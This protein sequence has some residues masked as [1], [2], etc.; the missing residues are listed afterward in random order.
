MDC[1]SKPCFRP[2][3]C[4]FGGVVSV[5]DK[6]GLLQLGSG[7]LYITKLSGFRFPEKKRLF[8][9]LSLNA[10]CAE[11]LFQNVTMVA[12]LCFPDNLSPSPSRS[13]KG[14][15]NQGDLLIISDNRIRICF[16]LYNPDKGY[17]GQNHRAREKA[18]GWEK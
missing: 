1:C 7:E 10:G 4:G 8:F 17:F 11:F 9:P 3:W 16:E 6:G 13:I 12:G 5:C 15:M 18:T 14:H 2:K